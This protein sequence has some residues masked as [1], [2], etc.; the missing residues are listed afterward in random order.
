MKIVSNLGSR[1]QILVLAAEQLFDR[2]LIFLIFFLSKSSNILA[3]LKRT[4]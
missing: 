3:I 2:T 1:M 4:E